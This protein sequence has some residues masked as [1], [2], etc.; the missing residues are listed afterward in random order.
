MISGLMPRSM[1]LHRSGCDRAIPIREGTC[2]QQFL[3]L[4]HDA[5]GSLAYASALAPHLLPE[6][7]LFGLPASSATLK[8]R[9]TLEEMASQMVAIIRGEQPQGPYRLLGLSSGGILAYEIA[10]QLLGDD[11]IVDFVGLLDPFCIPS[12]EAY[13]AHLA[14][15]SNDRVPDDQAIAAAIAEAHDLSRWFSQTVHGYH[16]QPI[17][18]AIFLFH[19]EQTVERT[20][21]YCDWHRFISAQWIRTIPVSGSNRSQLHAPNNSVIG[22]AISDTIRRPEAATGRRPKHPYSPLVSLQI[23]MTQGIPLFCVPG[24]GAT[25]VSFNDLIGRLN[26]DSRV[27]GLQPPGM[28]GSTIPHASLSVA[29]TNYITAIHDLPDDGPVHLLGHSYGGWVAFEMADRL[30]SSGRSVASVTMIDSAEPGA[31]QTAVR[32]HTHRE[33][34]EQWIGIFEMLLKHPLGICMTELD[35][36]SLDEQLL[37][38]HKRLVHWHFMPSNSRPDSLRGPFYTFAAAMRCPFA[39]THTLTGRVHLVLAHDDKL[40]ALSNK[41]AHEKTVAGWR[42]FSPD[43]QVFH[44]SGNHMTMLKEPYILATGDWLRGKLDSNGVVCVKA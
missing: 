44:S 39:P 7:T 36:Q 41:M 3:F 8:G 40:D 16:P 5:I 2:K 9:G 38:I 30:I 28:D 10:V 19:S 14:L 22:R 27:Y 11:A 31:G 32:R 24:A 34:I 20:G 25:I 26:M 37:R 33:V 23:G 21:V 18:A 1:H 43:L 35:A 6:L 29:V 13:R 15:F 17:E 42:Q 4:V 12:P